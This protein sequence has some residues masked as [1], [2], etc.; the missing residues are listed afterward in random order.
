MYVQLAIAELA[1][2]QKRAEFFKLLR[3]ICAELYVI[4]SEADNPASV[5]FEACQR[6]DREEWLF[7]WVTREIDKLD[8]C[9]DDDGDAPAQRMF[10][11]DCVFELAGLLDFDD[12]SQE[13]DM[14]EKS[15]AKIWSR[16]IQWRTCAPASRLCDFR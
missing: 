5:V 7:R 9:L 4:R 12:R 1:D 11:A 2:V 3:S 8:P 16:H 10:L 13:W 14:V 6:H 15:L